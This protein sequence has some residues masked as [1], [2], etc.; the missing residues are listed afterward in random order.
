MPDRGHLMLRIGWILGAAALIV[1]GLGLRFHNLDRKIFWYD[2]AYT[3]LH[4]AG[5]ADIADL[6]ELAEPSAGMIQARMRVSSGRGLPD[7]VDS[8]AR[9]EPQNPALY[10]VLLRGWAAVFGDSVWTLRALSAVTSLLAFPLLGWLAWQLFA[11]TRVALTS[12]VLMAGSPLLVL[13]AQEARAYALW[14]VTILLSSGILVRALRVDG[15]P[16]W[17]AYGGTVTLGLYSNPLFVGVLAA[18]AGYVAG[19]M[20][21]GPGAPAIRERPPW[22]R[23]AMASGLGVAGFVPWLLVIVAQGPRGLGWTAD[24]LESTAY[25]RRVARALSTVFMD[26]GTDFYE[27]APRLW[28]HRLAVALISALLVYSLVAVVRETPRRTG[29]LVALLTVVPVLVLVIPDLVLGGR[30][31]VVARFLMPGLLGGLLATSHL[32]ASRMTRGRPVC[33]GAWSLVFAALVVVQWVSC[34]LSARS[35]IWWTKVREGAEHLR[36]APAAARFVNLSAAAL[37]VVDRSTTPKGDILVL[38][39]HLRPDIRLRMARPGSGTLA[40][41]P[42]GEVFLFNPSERLRQDLET[43]GHVLSSVLEEDL[44]WRLGPR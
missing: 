41:V 31:A 23:F 44:L 32:F 37:V 8:V 19:L 17:L 14:M 26:F 21:P 1:A 28:L 25:P 11:S 7:V 40:A 24:A 6:L 10:F 22:R 33:R 29:L 4:L 16:R 38:A 13:L 34:G 18:H 42:T 3:A 15:W 39:R 35:E 27:S 36:L 9:S 5:H 30:R 43:Q 20:L 2:E 12:L